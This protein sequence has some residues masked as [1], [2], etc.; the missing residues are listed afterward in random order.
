M[1]DVLGA[2][3]ATRL[4]DFPVIAPHERN[5][6]YRLVWDLGF[7]GGWPWDHVETARAAGRHLVRIPASVRDS[8]IV[9]LA[10]ATRLVRRRPRHVV[11]KSVNSVFSLDWIVQRYRPKVVVLRRNPLN[12]VS[13]WL[14][15]RQ[16][17][18]HC[19]GD[20]PRLHDEYLR[21]L[22][23]ISPNGT[24]SPLTTVA[25]NVGLLTRAVKLSAERHPEWIVASFDELSEDPEPRFRALTSKLGLTWTEAMADYLR[26]SDDPRFTA[27][28]GTAAKHPNSVTA[29]TGDSRRKQQATQYKRRLSREQ[30]EEVR[31]VLSWFDLGDWGPPPA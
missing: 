19:L 23:L 28:H 1:S 10:E 2:M 7:A 30:V 4:G 12:V 18:D 16:G 27:H 22:G 21:P 29:T 17:T 24:A 5:F 14:V 13:S 31:A 8:I 3:A 11:V 6:W 20:D 9:S 26:R 25:W 15:L